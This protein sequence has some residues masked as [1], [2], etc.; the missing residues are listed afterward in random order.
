MPPSNYIGLISS[1]YQDWGRIELKGK[2]GK[3]GYKEWQCVPNWR[4]SCGKAEDES[5][6]WS[7]GQGAGLRAGAAFQKNFSRNKK[8]VQC[9]KSKNKMNRLYLLDIYYV[10]D[11]I[12]NILGTR[13]RQTYK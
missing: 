3:K 7:V 13:V 12:F 6:I 8:R 11:S 1:G 10:L 9:K 5:I 4:D 2:Q